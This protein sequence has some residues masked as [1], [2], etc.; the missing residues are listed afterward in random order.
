MPSYKLSFLSTGLALVFA[1]SSQAQDLQIKKSISVGGYAV[2]STDTSIKGP[3]TRDVT[4]TPAGT[5]VTIRQCDA[6]HII[7]VNE[8]A[9]TYFQE[10]QPL[11][12]AEAK[13]AALAAGAPMPDQ[14]GGKIDVTTTVTD[15]GERKTLFGYQAR[16][17]KS[18]I[19]QESSANACTQLHQSLEIDGWYADLVKQA[20][21]CS[22]IGPPV[23]QAQNCKDSIVMHQSGSGRPGYPLSETITTAGPDGTPTTVTIAVTEISKQPLEDA[24]FEIPKGYRQVN[25]LAELAGVPAAAQAA[26]AAPS[27][28]MQLAAAGGSPVGGQAAMTQSAAAMQQAMA[29]GNMPGMPNLLAMQKAMG[30]QGMAAMQAMS[31]MPGGPQAAAGQ[32]VAAPQVLG[33]KAPGKI[34]VGIAPPEAQLG[35]GN[36]ANA[37]YST[38]IRNAIVALMS[39]PA[40]EIAA[41]D[42]HVPIQLQAEAQQKQCDFILYSAVTVKHAA[43]GGLGGFMKKAAPLA[44]MTPMGGMGHM[45]TMVA[46][47]A[48][49]TAASMAAMSAQQQAI[50]QLA[51]FNGQIKSKDDVTVQYQLFPAGQTTA[52]VQNELKGKA[53]SDGEDVLTPLLQQTANTVLTEVTRK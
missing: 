15:T 39:G 17:L 14:N 34:R 5:N 32:Q 22:L 20:N 12:A 52:R 47:Q 51:S 1:F 19:V 6:R 4:Q 35:Q 46:A 40:V 2:S 21:A 44:S 25:S 26:A 30:S 42:S 3:R 53:K 41:L 48:A 7:H 50:N 24:L 38:P 45:G 18:K 43:S 49:S 37:D 31:A 13:A 10:D 28:Q 29:G 8:Q 36:N 16:H 27:P 23:P 11:T 33:P 9:Q